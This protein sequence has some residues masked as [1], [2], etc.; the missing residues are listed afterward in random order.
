[1]CAQPH[2]NGDVP[3]PRLD[4]WSR[5][6]LGIPAY[7]AHPALQTDVCKELVNKVAW[8]LGTTYRR[9]YSNMKTL[10]RAEA[11]AIV[12]QLIIEHGYPD[13]IRK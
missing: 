2:T 6:Y 7:E 8:V 11:W 4:D 10:A 13:K 5:E 12:K 1:V 3:R 9:P